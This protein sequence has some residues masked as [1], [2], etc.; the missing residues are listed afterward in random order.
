MIWTE[1]LREQVRA[2]ISREM[3]AKE[4]AEALNLSHHAVIAAIRYYQL[5]TA[6]HDRVLPESQKREILAL[7]N[8]QWPSSL[9]AR[10]LGITKSRVVNYLRKCEVKEYHLQ[11]GGKI[12]TRKFWD[13]QEFN[14]LLRDQEYKSTEA[15]CGIHGRSVDSIKSKLCDNGLSLSQGRLTFKEIASQIGISRNALS[16]RCRKI[17]ILARTVQKSR[18]GK[19]LITKGIAYHE[20]RWLLESFLEDPGNTFVKKS[21]LTKW[22]TYY[23]D[24][25]EA[26]YTHDL[27]ERYP[28]GSC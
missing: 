24:V 26:P 11:K 5:G 6:R 15:L 16:R 12:Q 28:Q 21:T 14:N 7:H 1:D 19:K 3:S 2:M 8:K 25:M 4:I 20:A 13:E 18:T 10:E 9:I 27:P 17:G 22:I 23:K